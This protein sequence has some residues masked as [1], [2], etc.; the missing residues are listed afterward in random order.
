MNMLR[1]QT[2][3]IYQGVICFC[4]SINYL[5]DY[6]QLISLFQAV[7]DHLLDGG[8]FLFDMH[9]HNR[10]TEFKTSW[11]EE[12]LIKDIHYCWTIKTCGNKIKHHFKFIKDNKHY[13]EQHIQMVFDLQKTL[14]LLQQVGFDVEVIQDSKVFSED[15]QERYFIKARKIQ[16]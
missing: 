5:S 1:W 14:T 7:Y 16:R 8:Y 12:G 10:L 6:S 2:S 3:D 13:Q 9:H 4:D 11:R 15:L